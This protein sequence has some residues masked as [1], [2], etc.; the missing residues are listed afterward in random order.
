[1]FV[2]V[3]NTF[4][5]MRGPIKLDVRTPDEKTVS[6]PNENG[7]N[8]HTFII[9]R[10]ESLTVDVIPESGANVENYSVYVKDQASVHEPTFKVQVN[11]L[12]GIDPQTVISDLQ[13]STAPAV[14]VGDDEQ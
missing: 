12:N 2:T 13:S 3:F 10:T 7:N 4:N 9:S 14:S 8:T 1:M 5:P 6:I 11:R